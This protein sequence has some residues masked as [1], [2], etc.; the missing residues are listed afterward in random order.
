MRTSILLLLVGWGMTMSLRAQSIER[1]VIGSA[2][3]LATGANLAMSMTIGEPM[4]LTWAAGNIQ[5]TQGFQQPE[6]SNGTR[7]YADLGISVRVFPNPSTG[8]FK[9]EFDDPQSETWRLKVFDLAGRSLH[10]APTWDLNMQSGEIDLS[11]HADGLY[12]L[13]IENALGQLLAT[14]KLEKLH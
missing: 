3:M 10:M 13:K 1:Q 7:I 4:T 2:G 12:L 14:I 5:L 9:V 11:G 8:K 6:A